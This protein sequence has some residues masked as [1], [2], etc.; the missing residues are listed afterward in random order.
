MLSMLPR[1]G[2]DAFDSFI[3]VINGDYPWL[4]SKLEASYKTM[5][6]LVRNNSATSGSYC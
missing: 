4:A 5:T 1:R 6:E 3:E 2:P